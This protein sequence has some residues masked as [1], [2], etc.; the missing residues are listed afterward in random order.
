[1]TSHITLYGLKN[2]DTMRKA[3][4]WLTQAGL[5]W[6]LHD[7]RR[8]GVPAALLRELAGKLGWE[9]LLN[10]TSQTWRQL[11][12]AERQA[13]LQAS[14]AE[15][16]ARALKLMPAHPALIRRPVLQLRTEKEGKT[17]FLLRFSPET[18]AEFFAGNNF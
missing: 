4:R 16:Q 5:D 18:Y 10:R 15:A 7:W 13:L 17:R 9:K 2:C 1:M 12:E 8:D 14:G 6:Q 11:P 3:G